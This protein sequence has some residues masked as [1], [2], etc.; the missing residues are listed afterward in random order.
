VTLSL[1][2]S[3]FG[4]GLELDFGR[5]DEEPEEAVVLSGG[6]MGFAIPAQAADEDVE[7]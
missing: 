5:V 6:P 4:W 7:D 2:L 3:L 1:C